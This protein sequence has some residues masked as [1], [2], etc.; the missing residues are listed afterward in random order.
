MQQNEPAHAL[1]YVEHTYE[2]ERQR[3]ADDVYDHLANEAV[4]G[5]FPFKRPQTI[6]PG[7]RR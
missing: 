2:H 7:V 3:S 6:R 1:E 5:R 4:E